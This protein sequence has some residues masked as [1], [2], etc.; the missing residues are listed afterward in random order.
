MADEKRITFSVSDEFIEALDI[1]DGMK[2]GTKSRFV[3]EAIIEKYHREKNPESIE[4]QVQM[5]ILKMFQGN[6]MQQFLMNQMNQMNQMYQ[7]Y[8]Q[9][10]QQPMYRDA[11]YQPA[12]QE[13][14]NPNLYENMQNPTVQPSTPAEQTPQQNMSPVGK[15]TASIDNDQMKPMQE[16]QEVYVEPNQEQ[17]LEPNNEKEDSIKDPTE[18]SPIVHLKRL[19]EEETEKTVKLTKPSGKRKKVVKTGGA[20]SAILKSQNENM[21]E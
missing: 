12:S 9:P 14:Y 2:K 13:P 18:E 3:C 7:P 17:K 19:A 21:S 15:Q 11:Y 8:Q 5:A 10:M 1:L 20:F 6:N 4:Q 16:E